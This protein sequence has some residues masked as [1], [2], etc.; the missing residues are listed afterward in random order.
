MKNVRVFKQTAIVLLVT[1]FRCGAACQSHDSS[2]V[3]RAIPASFS[4]FYSD[5]VSVMPYSARRVWSHVHFGV[6]VLDVAAYV[7]LELH[8]TTR[9]VCES[10]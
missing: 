2:R 9:S 5:F 6:V 1:S 4:L 10:V 8:L 3:V 7:S